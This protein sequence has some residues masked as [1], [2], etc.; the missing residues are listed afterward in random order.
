MLR[1]ILK[2]IL[3]MIPVLLGIVVIVF[4]LMY[5]GGGDPTISIL[6]ENVTPEAQAELREEL[7]LDDPYLVR[8]GNY[9]LDLLHGDLGDSYRSKRPVMDEILARY[10]TTLKLTFGS[11]ALGIVVGV[12]VGIISAVRQYSLLDKVG[13]FISLFGVS[14]PSFWIA[15]MLVLVFSVKLNLLPA[16]GSHTLACWVLPVVTLGL[17]CGAFIM[18][19]TRSSM[20]EVIRQDYIRTAKAKGQSEFKIVISHAF[21]NALVPIIT[22]IGI[23]ICGFLAGSVLV[24]SVFALPGLGKYVVDSVNYKD[25]PAVQGVVLFIAINCVIINLLTDI[26]YCFVDPRIKAQYGRKKGVKFSQKE[27]AQH[28]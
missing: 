17:Q 25:Y 20:L 15:M 18:R 9:L 6:G 23:Q 26:I 27:A 16:T 12:I 3:L 24:E 8:L 13:T 10:P 28:G 11:I 7:G 21:R 19:M 5:V 22:T 14:A 1:Y 2:R 4:T